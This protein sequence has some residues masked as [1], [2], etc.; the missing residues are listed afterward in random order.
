MIERQTI[1]SWLPIGVCADG[2][3]GCC[4]VFSPARDWLWFIVFDS[5]RYLGGGNLSPSQNEELIVFS[6]V[7]LVDCQ[8]RQRG[9]VVFDKRLLNDCRF[10]QRPYIVAIDRGVRVNGQE[11]LGRGNSSPSQT[12]RLSIVLSFSTW[13]DCPLRQLIVECHFRQVWAGAR[14]MHRVLA[15]G[16]AIAASLLRG[17][18]KNIRRFGGGTCNFWSRS[19]WGRKKCSLFGG[20]DVQFLITSSPRV[21]WAKNIR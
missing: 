10:R 11:C 4:E 5:Q 19:P 14:Y 2:P 7:R 6:Q 16:Y 20:G 3:T 21:L 9:F 15:V 1:T 17:I 8:F 18:T 13:R 12:E